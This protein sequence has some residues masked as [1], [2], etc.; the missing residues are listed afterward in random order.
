[1]DHRVSSCHKYGTIPAPPYPQSCEPVCSWPEVVVLLL[2]N[3]PAL[4][5]VPLA[6]PLK[7]LILMIVSHG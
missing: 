1:M 2:A 4:K 5:G 6:Q 3:Q 7:R